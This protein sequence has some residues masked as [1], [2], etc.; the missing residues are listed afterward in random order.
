MTESDL[1]NR[2]GRTLRLASYNI[3][4]AVGLDWK[5]DPVR[6]VNVLAEL[7]ADIV[8][9]QE[10]DRRFG[11]RHGTLPVDELR[12]SLGYQFAEVSVSPR[13]HGWHGNAILY[14]GDITL[15]ET[16]RIDLPQFEPRGAVA[17][18][19]DRAGQQ[20]QVIGLHLS[21]LKFARRKQCL[22]IKN[23][24]EGSKSNCFNLIGGDFNERSSVKTIHEA[25]G[26]GFQVHSPGPSFHTSRP[27]WHFD[28]FVI[29]ERLKAQG[30]RVHSSPNSQRASDHL[31]ICIDVDVGDDLVASP[32][33]PAVN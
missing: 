29:D 31:P 11:A 24:V 25:F 8:L 26:C 18:K 17:A 20:F 19:F 23:F 22:A 3:R 16:S 4:K 27:V 30:C 21:L 13:S 6:I 32:A 12:K 10:A 33:T 28:R 9:L 5:R 14:R 2:D 1:K 7:N 15:Q